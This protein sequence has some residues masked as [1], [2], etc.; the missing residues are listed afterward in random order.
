MLRQIII[1]I[2]ALRIS[3][4]FIT[5]F[6]L[7]EN[8]QSMRWIYTS[9]TLVAIYMGLKMFGL[10]GDAISNL[11]NI[12]SGDTESIK[13]GFSGGTLLTDLSFFKSD[14]YK[15]LFL[16][17]TMSL[18]YHFGGR[19]VEILYGIPYKPAFKPFVKSQIRTVI[20]IFICYI[21]ENII[22]GISGA[23]IGKTSILFQ[24][25]KFLLHSFFFGA[26]IIDGLHDVR[27]TSIKHGL[28]HSFNIYPGIAILFGAVGLVLS[29]I[30]IV[31]VVLI[32]S[33][34]TVGILIAIKRVDAVPERYV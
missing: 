2:G 30:P 18:V 26:V 13:M 21:L 8:W 15:Y 31:G 5:K 34:I 14:T 17:F 9:F 6:R 23:I 12:V 1:S 4:D 25:L 27:G 24:V 33:V 22:E 11:G 19:T 28:K 10:M 7:W 29:Y 32:S 20:A 16:F 3:K